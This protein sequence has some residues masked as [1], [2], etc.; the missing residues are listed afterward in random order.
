MYQAYFDIDVSKFALVE[1][2][3]LL[4]S[5]LIGFYLI[6]DIQKL[7]KSEK[8]LMLLP[9]SNLNIAHQK[10]LRPWISQFVC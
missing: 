10:G 5:T 6:A 1:Q 2:L 3:F 4:V 7:Q 9:Y 8:I